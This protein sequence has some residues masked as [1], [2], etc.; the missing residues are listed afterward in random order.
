MASLEERTAYVT[1]LRTADIRD[2]AAFHE[3]MRRGAEL[4]GYSEMDVAEEFGVSRPTARRWLTGVN[5][6]HYHV[7]KPMYEHLERLVTGHA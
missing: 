6:P 3:L 1:A 7:R 4:L 5:S 2:D